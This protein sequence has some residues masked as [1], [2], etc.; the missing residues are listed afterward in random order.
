MSESRQQAQVELS[1]ITG[2]PLCHNVV[3]EH[4]VSEFFFHFKGPSCKYYGIFL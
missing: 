4:V 2:G 3:F 1:V